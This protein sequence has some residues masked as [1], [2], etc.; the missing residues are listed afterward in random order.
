MTLLRRRPNPARDDRR[1]AGQWFVDHASA[2]TV[3]LS[4]LVLS[5]LAFVRVPLLPYIGRDLSMSAADLG[6]VTTMF[7]LGRL[8]ADIPAGRLS[9]RRSAEWLMGGSAALLG[10]ASVALSAAGTIW[11]V[12]CAAFFL[13]VSSA[14]V[15][16]AGMVYFAE[17]APIDRR[18]RSMAAFS[19]AL[20]GGQ[21]LGPAVG[22]ALASLWGWREALAVGGLLGVLAAG[23]LAARTW[24]KRAPALGA[25]SQEAPTFGPAG[26]PARPVPLREQATLYF[27][28]FSMFFTFGSMPQTLLPI[29]GADQFELSVGTIGLALRDRRPVPLPRRSDRRHRL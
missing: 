23:L 21:A 1:G 20:L 7:A 4:V 17:S 13:G 29:I 26:H 27:V 19:A 8:S 24:F 6:L 15:N 25:S 11:V 22:G 3:G 10:V 16:T 9:D 14:V 28:P 18:G 2:L 12:L 5:T